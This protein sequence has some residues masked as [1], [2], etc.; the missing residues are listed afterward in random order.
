[1]DP[2]S[3][4]HDLLGRHVPEGVWSQ[5]VLLVESDP[6]VAEMV[7]EWMP[8]GSQVTHVL[9]I[10]DAI[11]Q[12]HS[13]KPD[14]TF[15]SGLRI[16]KTAEAVAKLFE[17]D[18]K[19]ILVVVAEGSELESVRLASRN[20]SV[21]RTVLRPPARDEVTIAL[22]EALQHRAT[23]KTLVHMAEKCRSLESSQARLQQA[24]AEYHERI[25][26]TVILSHRFHKATTM[27]KSLQGE[28]PSLAS[29]AKWCLGQPVVAEQA[30]AR[31]SGLECL[32]SF[33]EI[34]GNFQVDSGSGRWELKKMR[35]RLDKF[36]EE[37]IEGLVAEK[38][39]LAG[40]IRFL[41]NAQVGSALMDPE[42]LREALA[43]LLLN[44]WEAAPD[45]TV[46]LGVETLDDDRIR[47]SVRDSG[48][49]MDAATLERAPEPFFST[50]PNHTGLGLAVA[51]KV[52]DAHG[53]RLTIVS[54]P[55]AGTT[56]EIIVP[57][58]SAAKAVL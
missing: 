7:R 2:L 23:L 44:A 43:Q 3:V 26:R 52:A 9:S 56:V 39:P 16:V 6:S 11:L 30:N 12:I 32:A 42:W 18:P 15:L 17:V 58:E 53:G 55:G 4:L 41:P 36:L 54:R 25:E 48:P 19:L 10:N 57:R 1:M 45:G 38:S 46:D 35:I 49:G 13:L 33:C 50:K 27:I 20:A 51:R 22:T 29:F 40:K 34:L 28:V 47:F 24:L 31:R 8:A 37:Y 14:V 5:K 21:F